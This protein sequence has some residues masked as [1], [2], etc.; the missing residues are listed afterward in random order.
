MGLILIVA[1]AFSGFFSSGFVGFV[2]GGGGEF[3]GF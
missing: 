3:Y 2:D 1:V